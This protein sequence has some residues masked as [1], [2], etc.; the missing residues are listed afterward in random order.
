MSG[1]GVFVWGGVGVGGGG[2][3]RKSRKGLGAGAL[4]WRA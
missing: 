1:G 4:G 3:H 2:Y